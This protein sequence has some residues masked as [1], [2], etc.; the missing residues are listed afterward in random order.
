MQ[1]QTKW[2]DRILFYLFTI[3]NSIWNWFKFHDFFFGYHNLSRFKYDS[4]DMF[5]GI[6]CDQYQKYKWEVEWDR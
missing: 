6:L 4:N 2:T 5:N 1:T 3:L